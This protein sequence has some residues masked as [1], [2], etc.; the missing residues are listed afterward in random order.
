VAS[1]VRVRVWDPVVRLC[2]WTLVATV[3]LAWLTRHGGGAWHEGLGYAALAV[4]ALRV[5]W[6]FAERGHARFA[7]FMR[8]PR[9]TLAYAAQVLA[10]REPRTLGHNPLGAWMIVALLALTALTAGSGW[11]YTMDRYWGVPWVE[12]LHGALSDALLALAALHVTGVVYTSRRHRENLAA[13][14]LHGWKRR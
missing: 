7:D 8:G 6:G 11:L 4:V 3:A 13:A 2:H 14:M 5:L 10:R 12:A 9:A 1:A